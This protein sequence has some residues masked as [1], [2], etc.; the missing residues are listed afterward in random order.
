MSTAATTPAPQARDALDTL[1]ELPVEELRRLAVRLDAEQRVLKSL[2]R[3]RTRRLERAGEL[4]VVVA[5]DCR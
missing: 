1:A 3:E 5:E 2:I 4:S